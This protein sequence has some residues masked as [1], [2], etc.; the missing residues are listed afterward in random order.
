M[1]NDPDL[2]Y[3]NLFV[4][5]IEANKRFYQTYPEDVERVHDICKLITANPNKPIVL[6]NGG[7]LTLRRFQQLGLF[8]GVQGGS[9]QLHYLLLDAF[10]DSVTKQ[11][12]EMEIVDNLR[13]SNLKAATDDKPRQAFSY[14]FLSS[15]LHVLPFETNPIYAILHE[16]IYCQGK[17]SLWSAKR[18]LNEHFRDAFE[19]KPGKPFFF[20]GEM[21]FDWMFEDYDRLR[22]LR[23]AADILARKSDWPPLYDANSLVNTKVPI[24]CAVYYEDMYV[25][26]NLCMQM[27]RPIANAKLWITNEYYHSAIRDNG[28][29]IINKLMDMLSQQFNANL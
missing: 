11:V 17:A 24:A 19:Y 7:F 26:F 6:A 3:K 20:T 22:P 18:V 16:S 2:V 1:V 8:L 14:K 9:E 10:V 5:V 13:E 25:D 23:K 4:R 12:S 15:F 27:A 28:E 29:E 21:I